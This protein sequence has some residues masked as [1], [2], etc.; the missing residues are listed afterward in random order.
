LATVLQKIL[1]DKT[2]RHFDIDLSEI[3]PK[4]E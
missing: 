4:T 2:S 1:V 3:K